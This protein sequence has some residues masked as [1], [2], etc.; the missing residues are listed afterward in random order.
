MLA[1]AERP[2]VVAGGGVHVSAAVDALVRLQS[3]ASLPVATTNMG[4]GSV[5]ETHP[6]SLGVVGNY[7]G[8][9]GATRALRD[10]VT[11]ADVVLLVGTRT[12]ENGTDSWSLLPHAA[13]FIHL[14]VDS[15]EVG[16]S[17]E[18]FRLVGDARLGLD[19]LAESLAG[20]DLT[21][22]TA[23]EPEVVAQI[24][25]G[26]RAHGAEAAAVAVPAPH[27]SGPSASWRSS[28]HCF[29]MTRSSSPMR[30]IRRSG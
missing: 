19:D 30:A 27:R 23:R 20:R 14:D 13:R 16:R 5:D 21:Q 12:N 18:A 10:L 29:R 15:A 11:G 22:R 24:A 2:L 4:K 9:R 17:Y 7:M 1:D 28:T 25:E 26:R 6:L 3:L 8:P